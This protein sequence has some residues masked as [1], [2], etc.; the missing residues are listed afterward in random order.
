MES[1]I[2]FVLLFPCSLSLWLYETVCNARHKTLGSTA[3]GGTGN[4]TPCVSVQD[5]FVELGHL[6]AFTKEPRGRVFIDFLVSNKK[7]I[8]PLYVRRLVSISSL[9]ASSAARPILLTLSR[10][11]SLSYWVFTDDSI[12]MH[13]KREG[14][15]LPSWGGTPH[16]RSLRHLQCAEGLSWIYRLE[17]QCLP[18]YAHH[19]V[20]HNHDFQTLFLI[21]RPVWQKYRQ[22]F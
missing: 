8:N 19:N 12:D 22:K 4:F 9:P 13:Q 2:R 11:L 6:E 21:A 20:T 15:R 17:G 1:F 7:K 16:D 14:C 10:S 18:V 5:P 3:N